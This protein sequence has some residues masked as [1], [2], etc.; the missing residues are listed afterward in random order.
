VGVNAFAISSELIPFGG[1]RESGLGRDSGRRGVG[2]YGAGKYICIGLGK[3]SANFL[4]FR[5]YV[6]CGL[7]TKGRYPAAEHQLSGRLFFVA[8]N[9]K[10]F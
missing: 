3:D 2:E 1:I 9:I 8:L 10:F 4:G 7:S 5:Y 6:T